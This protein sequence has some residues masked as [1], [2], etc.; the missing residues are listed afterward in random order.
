[1]VYVDLGARGGEGGREGSVYSMLTCSYQ[2]P[3]FNQAIEIAQLVHRAFLSDYNNA[4]DFI[5]CLWGI[6]QSLRMK[7]FLYKICPRPAHR[8]EDIRFIDTILKAWKY[9]GLTIGSLIKW[10]TECSGKDA[11]SAVM[12]EHPS[13]YMNELFFMK[14]RPSDMTVICSRYLGNID[15]TCP[16]IIIKS[17]LGTGKTHSIKQIIRDGGFSRIIIVSARKSYTHYQ[18]GE[19]N[20]ANDMPTKFVSYLDV[21]FGRLASVPYIIIQ[22]ESLHRVARDFVPY[23]LVILDECE[24][25]LN[26]LHSIQ[27]NGDN[28]ISNHETLEKIVRTAGKCVMAD[29]FVSDR[30]FSFARELRDSRG[31]RFIHNTFQP[32]E[33]KGILLKGVDRDERVANIGGFC[34]RIVEALKAS[35]KIVVV[36]TSRKRGEWFIEKYLKMF[37]GV[38]WAFYNSQSS[39]EEL[40]GLKNVEVAWRGIQCLMMTTSITV[41]INYAPS[42]E[43]FEFDEAFLYATSSSSLPRDI[44]QALLRVRVLKL[45]RLT[46][47]LEARCS[48]VYGVRGME[49]IETMMKGREEALTKGH[50]LIRWATIPTWARLNH[51]FNENEARISRSEYRGVLETYLIDCGYVL[52]EE[53]HLP[54]EKIVGLK[55]SDVS[56]ELREWNSIPDIDYER[57]DDIYMDIKHGVATVKDIMAY[58]KTVFCAQFDM[59]ACSVE[60]LK[61]LWGRFHGSGHEAAFWN[62]IREKRMTVEQLIEEEAGKRYSIMAGGSIKRREAIEKVLKVVGMRY[63][64]QEIVL[65]AAGLEQVGGALCAIG[66]DVR[67]GL[68]IRVGRNKGEWKVANTIDFI[69]AV[70]GEW[71]RCE[72][73]SI[74]KRYKKCGTIIREYTLEINK[75]NKFWDIIHNYNINYDDLLIGV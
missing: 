18:H 7:E 71:G 38:T 75:G 32:Y 8:D 26:Q 64:Q 1:L 34:E 67:E 28:L 6:E 48:G 30:T 66:G 73:K 22:V 56:D 37:K 4:R 52:T 69:R 72:V 9:C 10:A 41:G 19:L 5:W 40:A 65:D 68:G 61:Q 53:G 60:D 39:G 31:M 2:S 27:T 57:M 59:S 24:S 29:A 42:G 44:A 47:V 16:T 3:G 70:L 58:K 63:S 21:P 14:L 46:Y 50:P 45:N 36:W 13:H 33:R 17:R 15:I 74:V 20:M 55:L 51:Y 23:D 11:V 62:V 49:A 35:K 12:R 25:I 54:C 43:G